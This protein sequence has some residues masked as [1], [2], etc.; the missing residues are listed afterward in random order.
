[1]KGESLTPIERHE[2]LGTAAW[3]GLLVLA[4]IY[5]YKCSDTLSEA[6]RRNFKAHPVIV[7]VASLGLAA[8]LLRPDSLAKYD[9]MTRGLDLIK[10]L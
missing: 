3:A 1:M 6:Y 7:G 2:R 10:R 4:G 8:H 5:D 9:P